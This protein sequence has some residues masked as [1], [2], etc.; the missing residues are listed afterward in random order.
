M[1]T[2]KCV[3]VGD[4]AAGK[5]YLLITY[6]TNEF[7]TNYTP[8]VFDNY[9]NTIMVD[10]KP[11]NIQLWDTK[12]GMEYDQ[13]R[14]LSY[15]QTDIFLICFSVVSP[16]SFDNVSTKWQPEVAHNCPN[17]PYILVGTKVD[18]REDNDQLKRLKEKNTTPITTKQGAAK[19]KE[20]SAVKYI[21]CSALTQKNLRLVFDEAF[22]VAI[23][24]KTNNQ[25]NTQQKAT[26]SLL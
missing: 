14:A 15:P 8:T 16:P 13:L 19:A 17:T 1:Q 11:V 4:S 9:C 7:P 5:T 3:V 24:F 18:M 25:S 10:S 20:I 6:T 22:K 2:I 12:A 21:E 23:S 26:C